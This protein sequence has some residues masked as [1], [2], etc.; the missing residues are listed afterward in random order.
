MTD[1]PGPTAPS[2]ETPLPTAALSLSARWASDLDSLLSAIESVTGEKAVGPVIGHEVDNQLVQVRLGVASSL[3]TAL[4]CKHPATAAHALR[5]ALTTSAWCAAMELSEKD[6]DVIEIAAL[7]HDLGVVGVPD[8]I[9]QKPGVLNSNEAVVIERS[10]QMSVEILRASCAE[11]AILEIVE[12]VPARYDGNRPGY[13]VAGEN[14]PLGARMIAIV[15]SFDAMI[16]DQV[17]RRAMSQESAMNELFGCAGTQFDPELVEQFA[18]FWHSGHASHCSDTTR[19]WLS[20]LDSEATAG[21]WQRGVVPGTDH[22]PDAMAMF[23]TRL[24]DNMHDAVLFV[25]ADLTVKLWNHGAERMTGISAKA[26]CQRPWSP[27]LLTLH[28]EKDSPIRPSDCPVTC[29]LHS[30]VQSLRRLT[31]WSRNGRSVSV[32]THLIPVLSAEGSTLGAIVLLHD[33][34]P[35]I[36]LEERCQSLHEKATRDPLTCVANRAEFDRVHELFVGAHLQRKRPC[37]LIICDL[38]HFKQVNDTFGHQ[39]GDVVIKCLAGVLKNSC[40]AGDLV[41]RYGGEEFVMLCA[42]CDNATAA[43]RAEEVRAT[44]AGVAHPELGGQAVTASFGVTEIQPGDTAETMLRRADRGLLMAKAKGRNNVVQLGTGSVAEEV[45]PPGA[46]WT[47]GEDEQQAD[48]L[49]IRQRLIC[50]VPVGVAIEKL[51]GFIV[52]HQAK[53]LDIA[54]NTVRLEIEHDGGAPSR[55]R[56][57]RSMSFT[58]DLQ[59]DEEQTERRPDDS[60]SGPVPSSQGHPRTRILFT[61]RPKTARDRRRDGVVGR[62]REV[63]VSFRS[64]LMAVEDMGVNDDP[65]GGRKIVSAPLS[66]FQ[67]GPMPNG[68]DGFFTGL[69]RWL[70]PWKKQSKKTIP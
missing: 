70:T 6:R 61:I 37:S 28:D 57:D 19:R 63:L 29:T 1:S 26:V 44:L 16:T 54:N 14:L 13:H 58:I 46:P 20:S 21:Y 4:R 51:R 11:P 42:D 33:A 5:V 7:L 60:Q 2:H 47:D 34:S 43:R 17:Y 66:K 24:L 22:E 49:V 53:I 69:W 9:L 62:A 50:S 67:I 18:H 35:E 40:R 10:R 56:V 8:R 38:D 59:F 39:A 52:D 41:A 55:R 23:Q 25:G 36:S 30:G 15:E 12:N 27:E 65:M 48:E 45:P 31:I 68:K 64:Y 3:F 32:D